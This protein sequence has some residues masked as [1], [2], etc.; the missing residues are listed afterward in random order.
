LLGQNER[1]QERA[2]SCH[3]NAENELNETNN[4]QRR[5]ELSVELKFVLGTISGLF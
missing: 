1:C 5:T 4:E 3:Q 2:F